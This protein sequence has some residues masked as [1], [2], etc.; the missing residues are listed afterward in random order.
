MYGTR[1]DILY[2]KKNNKWNKHN[3]RIIVVTIILVCFSIVTLL[4]N[5]SASPIETIFKDTIA[6]IEYYV[7]KAPIQYVS[8]L[9]NEYNDLKDVYEENARLKEKLDDMLRESANNEVRNAELNQLKELTEIDYLP[10][11][12]KV[13]YTQI[14]ARDAESWNNQVT[15]DMGAVSGVKEGMAVI[16]S[17]GMIGTITSVNEISSTVSLLSSENAASQLPVMILSGD[18]EYYGL[19]NRY[20]LSTKSYRVTLLSDVESIDENAKVVTSGLGGVGKS[21]KGILVGTVK[22][23]TVS[24]DATESVCQVTPSA[25]FNSLA[26]VAVV[27]RVNAE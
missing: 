14:I 26:F 2:N 22:N 18:K 23:F 16:N 25:D 6:N 7:I 3:K 5:R 24:N 1:G 11:D 27:Q 15:I 20:D 13:Q 12:Y 19:L 8:G 4:I 21:P 17:Q 10:T 9:L